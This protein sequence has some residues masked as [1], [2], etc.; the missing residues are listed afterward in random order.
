[1]RHSYDFQAF[2]RDRNYYTIETLEPAYQNTMG[3][4][5]GLSF[6]DIKFINNAYCSSKRGFESRSKRI[7]PLSATC[8][9]L[10]CENQGYADPKDCDKCRCPEGLSGRL[11]ERADR[12]ENST[13]SITADNVVPPEELVC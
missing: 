12:G 7:A 3:Q 10:P 2:A 1:M 9:P 11:C 13:K 8:L 4:R 5:E 6:Y